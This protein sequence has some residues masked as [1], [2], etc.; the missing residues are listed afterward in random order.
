MLVLMCRLAV[1]MQVAKLLV[2]LHLPRT[3][4]LAS[5]DFYELPE[6]AQS[7]K[8]SLI[9]LLCETNDAPPPNKTRKLTHTH[10]H[11]HGVEKHFICQI[12]TSTI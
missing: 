5:E 9:F 12:I 2:P 11:T 4:E 3:S 6:L 8:H 1:C 7:N 10:T